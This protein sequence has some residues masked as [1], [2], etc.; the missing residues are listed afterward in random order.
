[1]ELVIR[2][3]IQHGTLQTNTVKIPLDPVIKDLDSFYFVLCVS[4]LTFDPFACRQ[5]TE[6]HFGLFYTFHWRLQTPAASSALHAF[7]KMPRSGSGGGG[8]LVVF[9]ER[10]AMT[11]C[12]FF[13]PLSSVCVGLVYTHLCFSVVML[14]TKESAEG[15][16]LSKL[17]EEHFKELPG[18]FGRTF[19]QSEIH[20]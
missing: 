4:I 16:R 12:Y 20:F 15:E 6:K 1:M 13:S 2:Q 18:F 5:K 11:N 17:H 7:Q 9:G 10:T 19:V 3:H 14:S 8:A